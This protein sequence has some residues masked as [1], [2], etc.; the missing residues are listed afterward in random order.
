MS[1]R[2]TTVHRSLTITR[3]STS[4][5]R[6]YPGHYLTELDT[7]QIRVKHRPSLPTLMNQ[8]AVPRQCDR[9]DVFSRPRTAIR[10]TG[11]ICA[12]IVNTGTQIRVKHRLSLPTLMN[13]SAVPR[14]CD[15]VDVFS[16]PRIAI[17][18]TGGICASIVN[19]GTQIR[20]KHRP[21]LPT[22]MNRS[23]VPRQ[24]D[25][26]DVF[27]RPRT[28]I[29]AT[30]GICAS[31]VNT[32]TQI[33]VKHRPSLPTL[34]NRSVVPRQC[35][36]V[37]V[38]SR[39]GTAI[40]ATGG[41]CASIVNTGTQIRVKHRP[42]LPTLM[43]RSVVPRQCDRVDVFSRPRTAIRA[44]GGICASIV[45]TG[46]QIRVKHRVSLPTLMNR[47]VV[48]RQCDRVDV[49]SR[50]RTAIRAT[51]GICASIVNTGT[52]IRV[53]H[54]LSLPTLMNRSVVPRQ[55]DRVDVFSRPRIAIRATGGICASIVNTGTQIRV[56][57]RPSLPTLMNRSA[58]PRQCDRVDV[59]SR[60]RTA[61]RATGGICA[62]IVNTGTQI[63]VKHR[64]SLPTLMNRSVVPRQCDRVDVFS[65][66]GTAIRATDKPRMSFTKSTN[67]SPRPDHSIRTTELCKCLRMSLKA[68]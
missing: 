58:V 18:A 27:S 66:P 52:Q 65:R 51:G 23:A 20:V 64:P 7:T 30:G 8:S 54:R 9:V 36:R 42:S 45:N 62:S 60:P 21:S 63:R 25:R 17:R 32:G 41:I 29:R 53:K 34:M 44:T 49:F 56:K 35:D 14:Q 31:I 1:A 50:P 68:G 13:R 48:P 40:R 4:A 59:F 2:I 55:C 57:H 5:T 12:S 28:A 46:T 67:F 15:R 10:A 22:L 24:C 16:R 61:I 6:G 38:F 19:T 37:D 3:L 33:R 11:G 43:N 39:P 47:S 26:V